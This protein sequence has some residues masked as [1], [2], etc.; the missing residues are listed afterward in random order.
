MPEGGSERF[1]DAHRKGDLFRS[2]RA[3]AADDRGERDPPTGDGSVRGGRGWRAAGA[4][5][6]ALLVDV[7]ADT[8]EVDG[9][10]RVSGRGRSGLSTGRGRAG[11]DPAAQPKTERNR[12]IEEGG[13]EEDESPQ[14]HGVLA[15]TGG[16][17]LLRRAAPAR[18]LLA[19]WA[20]EN[21]H[22]L[23]R[24]TLIERRSPSPTFCFTQYGTTL[25]V[26]TL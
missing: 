18:A 17:A 24:R 1:C 22:G 23:I 10:G 4:R 2:G 3:R 7:A 21:V 13:G 19:P 26:G 25:I 8:R 11:L 5:D 6:E 20:H 14:G 9:R 15:F 16:E 12:C